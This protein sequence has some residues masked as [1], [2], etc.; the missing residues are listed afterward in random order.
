VAL[1]KTGEG[2]VNPIT[3]HEGS[4]VEQKYTKICP[5][6]PRQFTARCRA[7]RTSYEKQ[8]TCGSGAG[9]VKGGLRMA[10]FQQARD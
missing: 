5:D 8:H 4:E 10:T 9:V 6:R 3:S 7:N 2:K 1:F